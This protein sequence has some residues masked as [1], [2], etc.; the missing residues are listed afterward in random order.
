MRWGNPPKRCD[1]WHSWFAWHPVR[2][3]GVSVW[4]EFL[5]RRYIGMECWEYAE[6]YD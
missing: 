5:S 1:E 2:V 4:L 3:D 6:F